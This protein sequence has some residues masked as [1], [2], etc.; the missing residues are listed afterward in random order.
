[1]LNGRWFQSSRGPSAACRRIG[2]ILNLKGRHRKHH[3]VLNKSDT[4]KSKIKNKTK[5]ES[6]SHAELMVKKVREKGHAVGSRVS[7]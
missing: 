6:S 1:M 7:H 4:S 2:R 5:Q 3:K